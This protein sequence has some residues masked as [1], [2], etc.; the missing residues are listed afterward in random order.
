MEDKEFVDG[1]LDTGFIPRFFERAGVSALPAADVDPE[2][3][4]AAVAAALDYSRSTGQKAV[5]PLQR[6][7]SS[8]VMSKR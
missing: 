8:W 4:I 6:K 1:K 2:Q 7:P 3:D 5:K